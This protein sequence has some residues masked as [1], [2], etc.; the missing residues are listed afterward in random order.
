M[1]DPSVTITPGS[2]TSEFKMTKI[3]MYLSIAA[4]VVGAAQTALG[5]IQATFPAW[6]WVGGVLSALGIL[7]TVLA[8]LGYSSAR[9]SV[10]AASLNAAGLVKSAEASAAAAALAR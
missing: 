9:A 4:A 1:A 7:G 2:E 10:K 6:G 5:S 8:S 3:A